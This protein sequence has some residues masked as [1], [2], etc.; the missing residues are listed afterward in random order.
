MQY[1]KDARVLD[2]EHIS[3]ANRYLD[4]NVGFDMTMQEGRLP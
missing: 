4:G 2:K 3:I 1:F